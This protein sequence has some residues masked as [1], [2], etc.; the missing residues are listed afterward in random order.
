MAKKTWGLADIP[1]APDYQRWED[2]AAEGS[3][4]QKGD[5]GKNGSCFRVAASGL[6]ANKADVS[7]TA[8]SPNNATLPYA[9]GDICFDIATKKFYQITKV[10]S[11]V[12]TIG[13]E[14]GTMA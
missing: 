11:G 1:E 6:T 7:A 14:L 12:A 2:S 13:V 8:L 4:G 9:V 10:A 3:K 5:P